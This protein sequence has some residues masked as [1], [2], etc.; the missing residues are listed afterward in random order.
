MWSFESGGDHVGFVTKLR[1]FKGSV[2]GTRL[3]I[4]KIQVVKKEVT[5][6]LL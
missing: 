4:G 2:L 1:P 5:D 6:L 3:T